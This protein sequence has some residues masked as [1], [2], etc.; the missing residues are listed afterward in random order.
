MIVNEAGTASL[1]KYGLVIP[2]NVDLNGKFRFEK[3][4]RIY[5]AGTLINNVDLGAYSYLV[6]GVYSFA[7]IGR[8]C[9]IAHGVEIGFHNHP[10]SWVSTHPFAFMDYLPEPMRWPIPGN[11]EYLSKQ[12]VIGN[13]VWIGAHVKI[14]GGITIGHGA[15]IATGSVVT[16]DVEPYTIVGGVPAKPIKKRFDQALIDE[17]LALQWWDYDWPEFLKYDSRS[18]RWDSPEDAIQ[19]MKKKIASGQLQRYFMPEKFNV[20]E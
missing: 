8:Y 6:S 11:F 14:M 1:L 12:V 20:I 10:I 2:P 7:S 19:M 13:D 5:S 16:A 3:C 15:V 9:S 17:L 4:N 18:V